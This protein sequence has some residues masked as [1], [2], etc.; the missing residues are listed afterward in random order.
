M[1]PKQSQF[2]C[3]TK[4]TQFYETF[5]AKENSK[6]EHSIFQKIHL[7]NNTNNLLP[8]PQHINVPR[9]ADAAALLENR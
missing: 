7:Q 4:E 1:K 5:F 3:P 2:P 8:R 6:I 9:F